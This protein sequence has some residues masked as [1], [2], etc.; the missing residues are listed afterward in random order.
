MGVIQFPG[1]LDK[2]RD[3]LHIPVDDP[4]HQFVPDHEVGGAGILVDQ[5]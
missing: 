3:G 5:E 1:P 2:R 4:L